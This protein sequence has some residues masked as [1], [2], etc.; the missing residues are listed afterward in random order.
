MLWSLLHSLLQ[1]FTAVCSLC[2][3]PRGRGVR[4]STSPISI[5]LWTCLTFRWRP[6]SPCSCQYIRG[7][8]WPPSIS[9][10]RIFKCRFTRIL[11]TFCASCTVQSAVLWPL[12]G[13]LGLHS[14]HGS[15]ICNSPF[16]GDPH[17][18]VSRRLA[19]PVFLS[20]VPPQGSSDCPPALP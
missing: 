1:A 15:C 7:T 9:R 19:R 14:G 2:G 4:S 10:K 3:R 12:H 18:T 17:E 8:G 5:A 6:F 16:H 20:G 11:V 13:S